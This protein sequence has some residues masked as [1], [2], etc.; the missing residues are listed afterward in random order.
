MEKPHVIWVDDYPSRRT[1]EE[2]G[3][4][5]TKWPATTPY[6]RDPKAPT[7][8]KMTT[9]FLA[10]SRKTSHPAVPRLFMDGNQWCA[11]YGENL[12]E[13]VAGF[14][15]TKEQALEAFDKEWLKA[16]PCAS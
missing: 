2:G 14:G 4:D 16:N 15:D 6:V 9:S 3:R 12:Q 8:M 5:I 13:G 1:V 10:T 7:S 11:L